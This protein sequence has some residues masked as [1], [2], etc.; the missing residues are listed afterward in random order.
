MALFRSGNPALRGNVFSPEEIADALANPMTIQG[1]VNKT[2]LALLLVVFGALMVWI[3]PAALIPMVWP[4]AIMGF[5][6]AMVTVFKKTWAPVTTPVY[7]LLEG[8]VLGAISAAF[9]MQYP[10]IVMQAVALTFG[11]L[12]SLLLAYK[13]GLIKPTENF[14]LG[15]VATTGAIAVV[16]IVSM[17]LGFFHIKVPLIYGSGPVGILFSLFVVAIAALNLVLDFDFIESG[18]EQGAPKYME[19]YGAFGLIVTLVWLYMEILRLLSK[20]RQR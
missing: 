19:W 15:I 2:L 9:E 5:V 3:N 17:L 11:T 6:V 18:A 12:F 16:Y 13:T 20:A 14:K 7:A 10:G 1:T 4:A 8:V